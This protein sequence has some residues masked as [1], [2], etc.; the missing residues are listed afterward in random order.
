MGVRRNREIHRIKLCG[1]IPHAS[2]D[3]GRFQF[4]STVLLN[5][6]FQVWA[7]LRVSRTNLR[8][9]GAPRA[10]AFDQMNNR[11]SLLLE[12]LQRAAN[13]LPLPATSNATSGNNRT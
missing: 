7:D 2:R 4:L 1:K 6:T 10:L 8:P 5:K 13:A 11:F 9:G 12:L 3:T